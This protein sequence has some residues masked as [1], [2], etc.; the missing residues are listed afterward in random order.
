MEGLPKKYLAQAFYPI[1][2]LG[3]G[4][5]HWS[6]NGLNTI[7]LVNMIEQGGDVAEADYPLGLFGELGKIKVIENLKCSVTSSG[8]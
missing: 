3:K 1:C 8:T 6:M 5:G 4:T 7:Y 2:I